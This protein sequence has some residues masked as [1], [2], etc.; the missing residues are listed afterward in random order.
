LSTRGFQHQPYALFALAIYGA[1]GAIALGIAFVQGRSP[2]ELTDGAAWLPL[3]SLLG[4]ALSIVAGGML[5]LLTAIA[6]RQFVRRFRWARALHAHLRPAVEGTSTGTLALLGVASAVSE[7]LFFRGVLTTVFGL[8]V[9][10]LAFGLLHQ[11]R[12]RSRWV[13]AVWATVMGFLFGGIYLATGSLLGPILAHAAINV[14]N[15][16]FLR[17]TEVDEPKP[18]RLGGL[19]GRA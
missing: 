2:V 5:A 16:R 8:T 19:L 11:A 12:G 9:S 4:H 17:D 13:W 1:L 3:P 14:A 6:T 7:E 15:L 18:R 10:S